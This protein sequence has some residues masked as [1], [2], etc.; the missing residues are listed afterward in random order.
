MKYSIIY[1]VQKLLLCNKITFDKN[2]LAFQIQSHPSYPSLHSITDVLS[3]F[4]IDNLALSLTVDQETLEQLPKSFLAQI[5]NKN[6][7]PEFVVVIKKNVGCTIINSDKKKEKLSN[8]EFLK[9]FTGIIVAVEKDELLKTTI[10]KKNYVKI[11]LNILTL[12]LFTSL[13]IISKPSFSFLFYFILSIIGTYISYSIIK[14][15][16]GYQTVLGNTFCTDSSE[17]KDCN[18]VIGSKG[19]LLFNLFKLSDASFVYFA[20]LTIALILLVIQGSNLNILYAISLLA[21]PITAYSI[22]YQAAIVKKW[23][24]LCL[25]IVSTLWAQAAVVLVNTTL[26]DTFSFTTKSILI[27]SLGFLITA[28]IW[29]SIAPKLKSLKELTQLK[30]DYFKFKRNFNLFNTL[31]ETS[32]AIDTSIA[33]TSEIVIG[34]KDTPLNITII[35]NPFCGHCK[36]VHTLV[37]NIYKKYPDKVQIYLR[38]NINTN[39]KESDDVKVTTRLLEIFKNN[40]ALVCLDAMHDIYNGMKTEDWLNK[41]QNCLEKENYISVLN[42][43]SEWC[44]NNEINFTPQILINGRSFPKEYDRS[45]LIYFIEELQ[46]YCLENRYTETPVLE[47]QL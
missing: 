31:L 40:D 16:Q 15:E 36:A 47:K 17:K 8:T 26:V 18:A 29:G 25:G 46:E 7:L 6:S 37:E 12:L 34:N 35:T 24:L 45:D 28:T 2:E 33:E 9:M 43:Q 14:Q 39:D 22:Y 3:H 19:A 41:W 13:F 23:C 11:G 42:N 44:K 1:Q 21:L 38:F 20:G 27:S 30:L 10:I 4:N 32:E 5:E